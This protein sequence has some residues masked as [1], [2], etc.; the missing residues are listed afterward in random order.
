MLAAM[1]AM[2]MFAAV[3]ALAHG[4][5]QSLETFQVTAADF[6]DQSIDQT[7]VG[8]DN[9]TAVINNQQQVS[10]QRCRTPRPTTVAWRPTPTTC[11]STTSGGGGSRNRL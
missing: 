11:S 10:H 2:T 4:T 9:E 7:V 1:L 3:P 5:D 8:D 6:G